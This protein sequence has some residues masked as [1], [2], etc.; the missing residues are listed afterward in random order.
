MQIRLWKLGNLEHRMYPTEKA[1]QRLAEQLSAWDRKSDFDIIW[2][3]DMEL[4]CHSVTAGCDLVAG[5][6]VRLVRVDDKT[7][8]VELA[9]N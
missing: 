6:G 5:D 7:I 1:V 8:R 9:K 4:V 2:G 3:P